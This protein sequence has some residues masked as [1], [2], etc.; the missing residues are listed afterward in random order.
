[1]SLKAKPRKDKDKKPR[2]PHRYRWQGDERY[3]TCPDHDREI[4]LTAKQYVGEKP[5]RCDGHEF[6]N[7]FRNIDRIMIT[8]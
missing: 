3:Y 7:D 2:K 4:K 5:V 8:G 1:M 6:T